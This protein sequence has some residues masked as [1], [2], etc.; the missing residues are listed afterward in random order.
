MLPASLR[1]MVMLQA[2][3]CASSDLNELYSRIVSANRV[4]AAMYDALW[5]GDHVACDEVLD[6]LRALQR[7]VDALIDNTS[8]SASEVKPTGRSSVALRSLTELL[9]GKRGRFRQTL[10]GRRVDYSG[11]SVIAPGPELKLYECG[12]PRA[13]AAELFKPFVSAKLMLTCGV[14]SASKLKLLTASRPELEARALCEVAE[15]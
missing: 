3:R 11:R 14:R 6:G 5:R 2:D 10:L 13:M 4:V 7:S 9:K 12:L 15:F 8:R 1:P